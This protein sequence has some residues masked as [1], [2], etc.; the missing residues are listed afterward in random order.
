MNAITRLLCA[1]EQ[2]ESHATDEFFVIVYDELR[3]LAA[4]KLAHETPGQTLQTTA[5]VHEAY[6]RLMS[7]TGCD[8]A[9]GS[10]VGQWQSRAHFFA[11]AAEAMRRIL[12]ESARRKGRLKRGGDRSRVDA[13]IEL[14]ADP[15][16]DDLLALD[17]ALVRL[18]A[19]DSAKANVV[20]L[21]DFA[22]MNVDETAAALR[23]SP[24]T[25]KRYW[26]YARAWLKREISKGSELP[27]ER[28]A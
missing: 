10:E 20:K 9:A 16:T 26:L 22:G 28:P 18:E 14:A 27:G 23:L 2:G 4:A 5:L 19:H 12:I 13:E 15:P 17:E 24:A 7:G 1:I 25:V 6:L 8:D 11:A 3:A 21:R